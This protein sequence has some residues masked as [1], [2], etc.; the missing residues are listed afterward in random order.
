MCRHSDTCVDNVYKY[1][2]TINK[3][4][5]NWQKQKKRAETHAGKADK[6]KDKKGDFDT[7]LNNLV[8]A[9]GGSKGSPACN[10]NTT[11]AGALTLKS[12]IA[13][14]TNCSANIETACGNAT[15]PAAPTEAEVTACS[16][17][18]DGF[19]AMADTCGKLMGDAACTCW[20]N[21]TFVTTLA[22]IINCTKEKMSNN[23]TMKEYQIAVT[24]GK[25]ACTDSFGQCRKDED[26]A[27]AAISTCSQSGD[28]LTTSLN[29]IAATTAAATSVK[30]KIASLTSGRM[31]SKRAVPTTCADFLSGVQTLFAAM[32]DNLFG[33]YTSDA[34][35]LAAFSG[36]CTATELTAL[37][38][39]SSKADAII[40]EAA[41]LTTQ[42]QSQIEELTGSTASSSQIEA[43]TTTAAAGS[44]TASGRKR[45]LAIEKLLRRANFK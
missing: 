9:G 44:A 19:T 32:A 24:A 18:M 17:S 11:S 40:A 15:T 10:G 42:I 2:D 41:V 16:T 23:M 39:E 45:R 7:G 35:D 27:G 22:Q 12:L 34:A 33:T 38:A 8:T 30:A 28:A 36:S 4:I 29:T 1:M 5:S 13:N 31:R 3:K 6:K 37:A 21:A 14:M 25:K 26:A 20:D 43:A